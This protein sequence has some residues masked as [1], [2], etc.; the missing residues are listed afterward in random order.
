LSLPRFFDYF[1]FW[2][3][4]EKLK[5]GRMKL[6]PVGLYQ[7]LKE[8]AQSR[9][10]VNA[11]YLE[12]F[13]F[14]KFNLINASYGFDIRSNEHQHSF[15]HIGIDILRPSFSENF[16]PTTFLPT[17]FLTINSSPDLS[18]VRSVMPT[19]A[20]KIALVNA[21]NFGLTPICRAWKNTCSTA[22]GALHLAIKTG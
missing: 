2:K 1:G 10:T 20:S 16:T 4:A 3:T 19:P 21:G 5:S 15:N 7:R 13:D 9:I 18:C 11:N 8:D 12:L 22:C 17:E 6:L 14:Y